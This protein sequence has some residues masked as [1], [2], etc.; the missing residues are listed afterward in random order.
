MPSREVPNSR[1][2]LL[3]MVGQ[4]SVLYK[5]P[6]HTYLGFQALWFPLKLLNSDGGGL[7]KAPWA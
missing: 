3:P 1:S 4:Q 6:D 2:F 7:K 5:G